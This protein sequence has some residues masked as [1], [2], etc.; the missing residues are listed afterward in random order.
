VDTSSVEAVKK[1]PVRGMQKHPH[2]VGEKRFLG[3]FL[4]APAVIVEIPVV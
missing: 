2:R 4:A 3:I 1:L